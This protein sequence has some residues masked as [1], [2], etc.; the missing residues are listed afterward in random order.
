M[1]LGHLDIELSEE[2]MKNREA[3][4]EKLREEFAIITR[5]STKYWRIYFSSD[6]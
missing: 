6:G 1:N 2:G 5:G 3:T 4:I